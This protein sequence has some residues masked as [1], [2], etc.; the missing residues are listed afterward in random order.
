[1]SARSERSE[2][3]TGGHR[4]SM[5][6]G[7]VAFVIALVVVVMAACASSDGGQRPAALMF[8]SVAPSS[9]PSP[10][11]PI[12]TQQVCAAAAILTGDGARLYNDELA[13][14]EKAAAQGDQATLVEAA[15]KIQKKFVQLADGLS[16][17]SKRSISPKLKAALLEASAALTEIASQTYAGTT[18]DIKDRLASLGTSFVPVCG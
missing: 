7:V 17:L 11:D 13:V 4:V 6:G 1:V 3:R 16:E 15:E 18:S 10:G 2:P 9:S 12:L 8:P 5:I 14:L